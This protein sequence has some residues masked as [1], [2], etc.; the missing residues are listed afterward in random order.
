VEKEAYAQT[1]AKEEED[2][3]ESRIDDEL[4]AS[5]SLNHSLILKLAWRPIGHI[6]Q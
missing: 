4:N 1:E 2:A 5:Y 6:S 3:S